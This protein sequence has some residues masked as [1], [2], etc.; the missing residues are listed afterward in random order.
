[1]GQRDVTLILNQ[2]QL[3]A[4]DAPQDLLPLV[5]D[6]LRQLASSRL[7]AESAGHTLQAT[8][9][10]HEAY[11]RLVDQEH[12][13][14]WDS[15]RHFF[16]AASEAMRR[17]LIESA[18]RKKTEKHGGGFVRHVL[19]AGQMATSDSP[20]DLLALNEALDGLEKQDDNAALLV[21]LRYFSGMSIPEASEVLDLSV[22]S[23]ERLWTY[24]K[25]WLFRELQ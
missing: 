12:Q 9:L 23:T 21:K 2:L 4:G 8:A 14:R 1:M 16:A 13:Q 24:A 19:D 7:R 17:I 6:E 5:Y 11:V 22:R 18:R 25:A 20:V 3:G 15:R 10:V